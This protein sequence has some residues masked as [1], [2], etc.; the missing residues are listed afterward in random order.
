[1]NGFNA[2]MPIR[3]TKEAGTLAALPP[4]VSAPES[5]LGSHPCVALSSAQVNSILTKTALFLSGRFLLEATNRISGRFLLEA[6]G[7][8]ARV[9]QS[10][11]RRKD[12]A[13]P[14]RPASVLTD[15]LSAFSTSL[16]MLAS[17][18]GP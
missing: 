15:H 1:M 4:I 17:V 8:R 16:R 13:T 18:P 14:T 10:G 9:K 7:T 12:N 5:A 11:I 3:W 6:T 2:F